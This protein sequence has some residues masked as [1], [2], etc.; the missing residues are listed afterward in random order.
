MKSTQDFPLCFSLFS[1]LCNIPWHALSIY[2]FTLIGIYSFSSFRLSQIMLLLTFLSKSLGDTRIQFCWST[3]R[4]RIA[5][6]QM[7]V[8]RY[9]GHCQTA[10]QICF[11]P[12]VCEK[13]ISS[14]SL[15]ALDIVSHFNFSNLVYMFKY[16]IVVLICLFLMTHETNQLFK[17]SLN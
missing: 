8:F 17:Q 2:F 7:C 6:L 4:S 12:A 9:D 15:K 16:I 13:S 11:T 5:E 14:T 10:F 3:S 1:L